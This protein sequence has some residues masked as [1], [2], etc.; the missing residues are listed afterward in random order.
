[1]TPM[2][3]RASGDKRSPRNSTLIAATSNG[4]VPASADRSGSY[5]TPDRSSPPAPYTPPV[6][7]TTPADRGAGQ[8]GLRGK[9]SIT[10]ASSAAEPLTPIAAYILSPL[11]LTI[12]FQLACS[13]AANSKMQNT[14]RVI[15]D[16]FNSEGHRTVTRA[17]AASQRGYSEQNR[18]CVTRGSS[19]TGRKPSLS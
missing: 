6:T 15:A 2:P 13:R 12:A 19:Y 18:R 5:P 7:R 11:A 9:G 3:S 16:R 8:R 17:R 1:M 4:A 10:G 14:V